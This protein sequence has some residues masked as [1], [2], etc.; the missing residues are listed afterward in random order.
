MQASPMLPNMALLELAITGVTNTLNIITITSLS[1]SGCAYYK[2]L[3]FV[4]E[5]R[6]FGFSFN[7]SPL[8]NA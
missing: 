1:I 6:A 8:C 2:Q 3:L 5:L 4:F 7:I